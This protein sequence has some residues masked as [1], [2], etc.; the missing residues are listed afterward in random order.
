MVWS[1]HVW[2]GAAK[3]VVVTDKQRRVVLLLSGGRGEYGKVG[4]AKGR[5]KQVL[6]VSSLSLGA[7]GV[8]FGLELIGEAALVDIKRDG[9]VVE[10]GL[11]VR[12]GLLV[13]YE[14]GGIA[15]VC[16]IVKLVRRVLLL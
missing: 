11:R 6:L 14:A 5:R 3:L 8:V 13:I 15:I 2:V 10:A 9:G 4:F 7:E 1:H 12:L 16:R